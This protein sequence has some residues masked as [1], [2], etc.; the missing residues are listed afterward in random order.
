MPGTDDATTS[1]PTE[2][3]HQEAQEE[4]EGPDRQPFRDA[5]SWLA[6]MGVARDPLVV[7][8]PEQDQD[9][10]AA[11][12]PAEGPVQG[13]AR[14]T[15]ATSG[16]DAGSDDRA[17]RPPER[18]DDQVTEAIT[19]ARRATATTP[20]AE[21]RL[22]RKM[23]S[24]GYAPLV[25]EQAMQRARDQGLVDD[26][27]FA[28]SL[29][30]EGRD[31]GHAPL[32]IKTDLQKR[33]LS[34]EAIDAALDTIGDRDPEAQAFAVAHDRAKRLRGVDSETAY[35]RLVGYLARR[36]YTESLSRKVARQAVFDDREPQRVAEH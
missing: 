23:G 36:G 9:G 17:D 13:P 21:T 29:V 15:D 19:Y 11:P 30:Q 5:E 2:A 22:E 20:L 18:L 8:A 3:A 32:R 26:H 16:S 14:P 6:E 33:E 1:E 25:I 10:A 28:R 27:A 12:G 4:A 7:A 35:R 34:S 31:K 24:R